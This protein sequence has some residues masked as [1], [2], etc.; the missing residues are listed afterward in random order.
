MARLEPVSFIPH[1]STLD[2]GRILWTPVSHGRVINALPQIFWAGGS[3]WREANLWLMEQA[4]RRD[5]D[6]KTV[7]AKATSLHAYANWLEKSE[8]KWWDFPVRK[9]DRC[10]VRYR[11]ALLDARDSSEIAPSTA[12]Q[13]MRVVVNFYRWLKA[14][15]LLSPEW[16]LWE[17]RTVG[18]HLTNPFGFERTLTVTTTDLSIPN[19]A[20]PGERL[21]DGL[22]PVSAD[23][24]NRI[25][26]F[27]R[28]HASEELFLLLTAGFFTG[29]RLQTLADLRIETLTSAVPDPADPKLYR[30]A[31][32]PGASPPVATKFGVSGQIWITESLLTELLDYAYG[33]R[34]LLR[35]AKASGNNKNLLFLTRF[36]NP[37]AQRGSDKSI[38]INVEMHNFKKS[39]VRNGI[40]TMRYFR[41]HQTRCT[42]AT[43]LAS[44]AISI[45]GG[46]H[47]VAVIKDALLHKNES[48]AL[49]YIKFIEK[50]PIKKELANSFTRAFLGI[51]SGI[52]ETLDA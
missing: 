28:E 11:G 42:F 49:K 46:I 23:D 47:A 43:E 52:E 6:I 25:L 45:A 17:E 41:F 8:S 18:I 33:Q 35:E 5:V 26:T 14:T 20:R 51:T 44:L 7:N 27:A 24:R 4:V 22:L 50:T 19:R 40:A 30:L 2:L 15:R 10:L 12:T 36:G 48:T 21:E 38:A 3:P 39:A 13:R 32:G 1:R 31:V 29:M 16:P 34:R 37:Y 9:E